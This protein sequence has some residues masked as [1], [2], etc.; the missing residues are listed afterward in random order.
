MLIL[1]GSM[2]FE[3]Y[4]KEPFYLRL[5]ALYCELHIALAG[6]YDISKKIK[7]ICLFNF[8]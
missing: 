1:R 6:G 5:M 8:F 4:Q 7:R 3:H 2:P